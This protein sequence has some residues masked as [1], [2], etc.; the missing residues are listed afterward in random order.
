MRLL[1]VF[2]LGLF[3]FSEFSLAFE[4]KLEPLN[5]QK[6]NGTFLMTG[7]GVTSFGFSDQEPEQLYAIFV[8]SKGDC[9]HYSE[10]FIPVIL[11]EKGERRR[12]NENEDSIYSSYSVGSMGS[13]GSSRDA[14]KKQVPESEYSQKIF[15][16]EKIEKGET[17]GQAVACGKTK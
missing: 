13:F 11:D 9:D 6:T 12:I 5:G 3:L 17:R 1:K 10:L 7:N 2:T 8:F 14:S 16:L 15:V 4:V